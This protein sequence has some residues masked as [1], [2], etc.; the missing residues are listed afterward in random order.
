MPV[1]WH[2]GS[3]CAHQTAQMHSVQESRESLAT[4]TL[5]AGDVHPGRQYGMAGRTWQ[6]RS[7]ADIKMAYVHMNQTCRGHIQRRVLTTLCTRH[8]P[9]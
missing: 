7:Q 3:L 8:K 1:S 6:P 4:L 2:A 5:M 9:T